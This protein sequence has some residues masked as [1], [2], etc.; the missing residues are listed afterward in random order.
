MGDTRQQRHTFR[1]IGRLLRVRQRASAS[2]G[3]CAA[4]GCRTCSR[5]TATLYVVETLRK[6]YRLLFKI[7][8]RRTLSWSGAS[9]W[10][11]PFSL[12]GSLAP[13][14]TGH[15]FQGLLLGPGECRRARTMGL[16]AVLVQVLLRQ[17]VRRWIAMGDTQSPHA[18]C[19]WHC[20]STGLH[21]V[22]AC[23]GG[24]DDCRFSLLHLDGFT[25]LLGVA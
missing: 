11:A 8:G 10:V 13:T 3:C 1:P 18:H 20:C 22:L 4:A 24:F 15:L 7:S 2:S 14:G 21:R 17:G 25:S 16:G 23:G 19:I 9:H 6:R 5:I 12:W